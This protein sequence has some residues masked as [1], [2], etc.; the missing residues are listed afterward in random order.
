MLKEFVICIIIIISIIF[1][2]YQ[3]QNY[4]KD[5]VRT[6]VNELGGL[7]KEIF[8][9]DNKVDE[10]NVK[11]KMEK[12]LE[13]WE[14]RHDK[15]AYFIEHD[16]LEKVETSLTEIRSYVDTGEYKDSISELDKGEFLL[17]HIEEKYAFTLKNIF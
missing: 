4:T 2:N 17:K 15:L 10:E 11:D 14:S 3:T 7:R 13:E 12:V 8:K 6:L 16:E 9:E 5:S 1:G